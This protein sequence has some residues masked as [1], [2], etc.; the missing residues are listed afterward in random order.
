MCSEITLGTPVG[1]DFFSVFI[2][3]KKGYKKRDFA[4]SLFVF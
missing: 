4:L 2:S 3:S 1:H